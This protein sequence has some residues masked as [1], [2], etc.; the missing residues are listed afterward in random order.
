MHIKE[1]AKIIRGKIEYESNHDDQPIE[2]AF[3]CDLMSDVLTLDVHN[4]LLITGLNNIQTIRTA[5]I[6]DIRNVILVR[7]KKPTPDMIS[8]AKKENIT[9]VVTGKTL[10]EVSGILHKAGLKPVY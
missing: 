1:I 7:N 2:K 4:V 9:I 8:L 5:E 10:F 6:A 3:A